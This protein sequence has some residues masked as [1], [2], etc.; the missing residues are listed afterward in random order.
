MTGLEPDPMLDAAL[1]EL[2]PPTLDP[3]AA[4]RL[5]AGLAGL[6]Q[7]PPEGFTSLPVGWIALLV[8]LL[9]LALVADLRAPDPPVAPT[10]EPW[11]LRS[12]PLP[13]GERLEEARADRRARS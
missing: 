13:E 6:G 8:A 11:Q 1:G 10:R 7:P 3:A 2:A 5:A 12:V 9:A 4:E